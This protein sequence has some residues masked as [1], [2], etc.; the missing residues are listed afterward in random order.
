M[1]CLAFVVWT[2][3]VG[4]FCYRVGYH[5]GAAYVFNK[6]RLQLFGPL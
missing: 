5:S 4:W 1:D 6:V 3:A 2:V